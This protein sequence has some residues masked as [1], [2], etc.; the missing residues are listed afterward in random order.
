MLLNRIIR[1]FSGTINIIKLK[2]SN[3][4][5]GSHL[6]IVGSFGLINKGTFIIGN[7]F[8]CSS[9]DMSNAM[10]RNVKS[11]FKTEKG[12]ILKIANDVGIASVTI[13][14][15]NKITIGNNVKI[16]ALSIITDTD[17]HSLNPILRSNP[18]TD[19]LN[20]KTSPITIS[21]NVFIGTSCIICKGVSIGE[22]AVIGAGSI[23]TK[24]IPANEIWAGNP[25]KFIRKI[26]INE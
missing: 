18:M 6:R 9:G 4:Q 10:A 7:N 20:A 25:A 17:A 11:Y 1:K 16:G 26:D 21:D 24:N 2:N 12:A 14:C 19:S 22:N 23:V 8:R 13:R 3:V 5:F 15:A